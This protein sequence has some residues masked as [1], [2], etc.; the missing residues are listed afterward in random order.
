MRELVFAL[1]FRGH[2]GPAP[3]L[4][5]RRRARSAAPSQV[6]QTVL[7][8]EALQAS[9]EAVA[10]GSATLESEIERF[11]DGSFEE[12][13]TIRYGDLGGVSFSTVGRGVVGPSP[14]AG[15]HRG[16]VIWEVTAGDGRFAGAQG[17]I[18]SNFTV[19]AEGEVVD[20][21]VARFYLP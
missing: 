11:A 21:H 4:P 17:L 7:G 3:G 15:W 18:T 12:W 13:G 9:R 1:E 10:G 2:A 20:D 14:L 16:A 8:P 6:L 5:R 19:S